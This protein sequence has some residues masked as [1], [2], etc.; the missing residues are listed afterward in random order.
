MVDIVIGHTGIIPFV[1]VT[2]YKK[3][4]HQAAEN[5]YYTTFEEKREPTIFNETDRARTITALFESEKLYLHIRPTGPLTSNV[6]FKC[7]DTGFYGEFQ[8][9]FTEN[10]ESFTSVTPL[11]SDHRNF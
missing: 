7:Y 10:Q 1:F 11:S 3:T 4:G 9:L 5:F 2:F 6:T 8:F